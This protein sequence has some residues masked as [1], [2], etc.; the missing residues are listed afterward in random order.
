MAEIQ[1]AGF[2]IVRDTMVLGSICE[3]AY[4]YTLLLR[5]E[6]L[7]PDAEF[8]IA[9]EVWGS[10]LLLDHQLGQTEFDTHRPVLKL[11]QEVARSFVIPCDALNE[12]PGE[13]DIFIR[14]CVRN[15]AGQELCASSETLHDRF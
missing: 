14:I 2:H 13:D 3:V 12:E 7:D 9:V 1:N 10:G 11:R 15:G 8:H 4:H 6:E 5:T